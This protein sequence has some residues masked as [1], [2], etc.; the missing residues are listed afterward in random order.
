MAYH[1]Q[2][3]N[4][5]VPVLRSHYSGNT[6]P[7]NSEVDCRAYKYGVCRETCG[8]HPVG[9][10]KRVIKARREMKITDGSKI[11]IRA[12]RSAESKEQER[13]GAS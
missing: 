4:R 5:G 3:S 2:R 11:L 7:Y 13:G 12:I 8:W 1:Y 10:S 6:C 9:H